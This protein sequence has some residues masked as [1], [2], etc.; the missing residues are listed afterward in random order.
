MHEVCI[1]K[2]ANVI[3]K[4]IGKYQFQSVQQTHWQTK[5]AINFQNGDIYGNNIVIHRI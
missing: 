1:Y 4:Y 3:I 5:T 2:E